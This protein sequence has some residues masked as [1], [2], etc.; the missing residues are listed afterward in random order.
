MPVM[1]RNDLRINY[2]TLGPELRG[3]GEVPVALIHGLGANLSFW[4]LGASRHMGTA[5]PVIM[6][7]LRGHGAS[8]MPQKGYALEDLAGDFGQLMD[9]LGLEQAHVVGHSH[10]ARVALAYALEHPE[11][12]ASLTLADTQI[13]SIQ[14]SVRLRDW[15]HWPAWRAELQRQGV[16]QFPNDDAV[17]DFRLLADL[18]PR[19]AGVP[20]PLAEPAIIGAAGEEMFAGPNVTRLNPPGG[21]AGRRINLR[22]RQMGSRS[23]Q[24]WQALLEQTSASDELHDE[25][26]LV[27]QSLS[28]LKMPVM[29]MYG[30][31]SHC[32]PTADRLLEILPNA[33]RILIP[34]GGHFFPI[35]KP[36]VF[37]RA[38][39]VFLHGIDGT[40]GTDRRRMFARVL[41]ANAARA[42]AQDD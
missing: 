6:H 15:P 2:Q 5:R 42:K 4:Y 18:G 31:L 1:T 20:S 26:A 14:P 38:L 21:F 29:L 23:S 12:V 30:A 11:R 19:G 8:S 37:S 25:S 3:H 22:S 32:V 9:E 39:N 7:D 27:P 17:I 40:Q 28:H 33:R 13:R 35:V 24:R 10:G 16:S 34:G 36:R 41:A